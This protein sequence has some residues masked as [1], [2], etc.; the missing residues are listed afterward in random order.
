M[1]DVSAAAVEF[2]RRVVVADLEVKELGAGFC[3]SCAKLER[4]MLS[5]KG[6]DQ[7]STTCIFFMSRSNDSRSAK[8]ARS[9][10]S[11]MVGGRFPFIIVSDS[12][13]YLGRERSGD[14]RRENRE[15][16]RGKITA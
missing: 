9:T 4:T 10:R 1:V 15:S 16:A 7:G 2:D 13:R 3:R 5:S 11:A 14:A 12:R 6:S 8:V